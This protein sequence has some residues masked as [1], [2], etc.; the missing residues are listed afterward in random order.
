MRDSEREK[1]FKLEYLLATRA[2]EM[3]VDGGRN[4]IGSC[5]EVEAK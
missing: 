5:K 4:W 2:L 3:N 1:V